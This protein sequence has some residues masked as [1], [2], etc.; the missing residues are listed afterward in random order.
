MVRYVLDIVPID[1]YQWYRCPFNVHL[2]GRGLGGPGIK[3]NP[4]WSERWGSCQ[5][6]FLRAQAQASRFGKNFIDDQVSWQLYLQ[7]AG[8]LHEKVLS[9]GIKDRFGFGSLTTLGFE[10]QQKTRTQRTR[11][12]YFQPRQ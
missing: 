1:S 4:A 11:R 8:T 10:N 12:T 6:V 5:R 2:R 7:D 9:V 3:A